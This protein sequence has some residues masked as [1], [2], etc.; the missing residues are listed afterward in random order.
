MFIVFVADGTVST[1]NLT[2]GFTV[3]FE[4]VVVFRASS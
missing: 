2:T 1:D 4:G 3:D